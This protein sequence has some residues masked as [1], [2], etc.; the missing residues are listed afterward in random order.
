MFR[1]DIQFDFQS[2]AP[3]L[4]VVDNLV[5][6]SPQQAQLLGDAEVKFF[7][8]DNDYFT[9]ELPR[10]LLLPGNGSRLSFSDTVLLDQVFLDE[11]SVWFDVMPDQ[12]QSGTVRLVSRGVVTD[13]KAFAINVKSG[14]VNFTVWLDGVKF[15]LPAPSYPLI[16][17]RSMFIAASLKAGV[18]KLYINKV[19]R[20]SFDTM[21]PTGKMPSSAH[22]LV[23]GAE[24]DGGRAFTG[25]IGHFGA[26]RLERSIFGRQYLV[27]VPSIVTAGQP[28]PVKVNHFS[29]KGRQ[30]E[31]VPTLVRFVNTPP[32][33][34]GLPSDPFVLD[35]PVTVNDVVCADTAGLK[36][37]TLEVVDG[38]IQQLSNAFRCDASPAQKCY[39]GDFHLHTSFEGA[40]DPD[41]D[42]ALGTLA[43]NLDF[44]R[45]NSFLDALGPAPHAFRVVD[46]LDDWQT[47][48]D[49]INAYHAPGWFATFLCEEWSGQINYREKNY[50]DGDDHQNLICLGNGDDPYV[51]GVNA[52][53]DVIPSTEHIYYNGNVPVLDTFDDVCDLVEANPHYNYIIAPHHLRA[54]ASYRDP[55]TPRHN[56]HMRS[57]EVYSRHGDSF[58]DGSDRATRGVAKTA[59]LGYVWRSALRLL[60]DGYK[61]GLMACSD[62]HEGTPGV[63]CYTHYPMPYKSIGF[64]GMWATDLT[65][66]ALADSLVSRRT[67]ATTGGRIFLEVSGIYGGQSYEVGGDVP[68]SAD[69]DLNL[70]VAI[71]GFSEFTLEVIKDGLT[72]ETVDSV[73]LSLET[74]LK[75][76]ITAATRYVLLYLQQLDGERAWTSPFF[77]VTT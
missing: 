30:A 17:G 5:P 6:S 75:V 29:Q 49:T 36:R 9:N 45:Y 19:L 3:P 71:G 60:E 14:I 38:N 62:M 44:A 1:P 32:G 13:D 18:M 65:R 43:E 28:F 22:P 66:A 47:L 73:G 10:G 26:I 41:D 55:A 24:I 63:N 11:F 59:A 52:P 58:R 57:V 35:A 7:H 37:F 48:I 21:N 46:Q 8:P 15:Q 53:Q 42:Y 51:R 61:F 69:G 2:D 31:N 4:T 33:I 20:A 12:I 64:T 70:S 56:Q 27:A 74:T 72:T 34:T 67:V 76:P 25:K 16:A 77:F 50:V 39:W 68:Y 40:N 54:G 23:I